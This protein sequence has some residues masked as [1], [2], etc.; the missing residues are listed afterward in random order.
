MSFFVKLALPYLPDSSQLCFFMALCNLSGGEIGQT[1]LK[2]FFSRDV[3]A[4]KVW[5]R[6][7]LHTKHLDLLSNTKYSSCCHEMASTRNS[8]TTAM[9]HDSDSCKILIRHRTSVS[10]LS[11]LAIV[12]YGWCQSCDRLPPQCCPRPSF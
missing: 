12:I 3:T 11:S 7:K 4:N 10:R 6:C 8:G 9:L 5:G 2:L 1:S